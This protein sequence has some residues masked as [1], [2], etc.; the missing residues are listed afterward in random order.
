[1]SIFLS[2]PAVPLHIS[3]GQLLRAHALTRGV[4]LGVVTFCVFFSAPLGKSCDFEKDDSLEKVYTPPGDPCVQWPRPPASDGKPG[5]ILTSGIE[6]K[7]QSR[8]SYGPKTMPGP[9]LDHPTRDLILNGPLVDDS[10]KT[11][12]GKS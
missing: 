8:R 6:I 5:F 10:E 2:N 12:K 11:D 9:P 4:V 1:M 3:W 7:M